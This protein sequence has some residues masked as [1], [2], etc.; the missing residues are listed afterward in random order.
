MTPKEFFEKKKSLEKDFKSK[1]RQLDKQIEKTKQQ[2][3]NKIRKLNAKYAESTSKYKIGDI[4]E[5]VDANGWKTA[6]KISE[7]NM[8]QM[9]IDDFCQHQYVGQLY[10]NGKLIPKRVCTIFEKPEGSGQVI[11]KLDV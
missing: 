11:T 10:R 2:Y 3:D 7:I 4:I 5:C 9:S 1:L 8:Y 6:I